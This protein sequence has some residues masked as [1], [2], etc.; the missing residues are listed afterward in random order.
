MNL[1]NHSKVEQGIDVLGG[2]LQNIYDAFGA[3]KSSASRILLQHGLGSQ[4]ASKL[5]EFS[6][7][8]W[9]PLG[10]FLEALKAIGDEAGEG[11]LFKSGHAVPTNV[12]WPPHVTDV[13][14]ALES[15]DAAYHMNHGKHGNPLFDPSTG[16]MQEGIGHY[17]FTRTGDF[18]QI[19]CENPYP[20]M[21]DQGL[22]AAIATQFKQNAR[23][24][25]ASRSPCR[26]FGD[27]HC[28]YNIVW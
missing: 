17:R 4:G 10:K 26:R 28:V 20:C 11:V 22:I 15:I 5:A 8:S 16:D 27:S 9:Y 6:P 13:F 1:T 3:F 12:V 23:V 21:F 7:E 18:A 2:C 19:V 24:Q 14:S 25:H